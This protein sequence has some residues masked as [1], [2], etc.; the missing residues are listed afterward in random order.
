L[1]PYKE[2]VIIEFEGDRDIKMVNV[3][4]GGYGKNRGIM[5]RGRRRKR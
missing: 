5:V 3:G 2:I 1:F 4:G